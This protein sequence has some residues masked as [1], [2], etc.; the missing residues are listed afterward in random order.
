MRHWSGALPAKTLIPPEALAHGAHRAVG[1]LQRAVDVGVGVGGRQEHVVLR[2][3]PGA[4]AQRFP[5]KQPAFLDLG[6][7]G[8]L[9]KILPKLTE[10]IKA[11]KAS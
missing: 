11:K 10:A 1:R 6:I 5:R 7:V 2:M 3:D 9:N 8:D 4:A